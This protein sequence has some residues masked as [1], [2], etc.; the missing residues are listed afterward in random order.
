MQEIIL[1]GVKYTNI[2]NKKS[3]TK[4]AT[5]LTQ[6]NIGLSQSVIDYINS[7]AFYSLINS[8]DIDWNGI[9]LD[10][11]IYINDTSDLINWI[12][13]IE[14]AHKDKE[15]NSEHFSGLGRKT[16]Q[17]KNESNILTQ[18]DFD[19]ENTIYVIS[20]DFDLNNAEITIP[21]GCVLK[22]N[23]GSLNNGTFYGNKCKVIG[24]PKWGNNIIYCDIYDNNGSILYFSKV[25]NK[26]YFGQ[27]TNTDEDVLTN[28]NDIIKDISDTYGEITLVFEKGVTYDFGQAILLRDNMTVEGNGC[29]I[30]FH[31]VKNQNNNWVTMYPYGAFFTNRKLKSTGNTINDFAVDVKYGQKN[32]TIKNI[33]FNFTPQSEEFW[34]FK[35]SERGVIAL[36]GVKNVKIEN[37]KFNG[38]RA[39]YPIWTSNIDGI[40]VHNCE[41]TLDDAS[42][43]S[44]DT[45]GLLWNL[46][47]Y[48]KDVEISHNKAICYNDEV[49]GLSGLEGTLYVHDNDFTCI[50]QISISISEGQSPKIYIENN[51]FSTISPGEELDVPYS[52]SFQNSGVRNIALLS[53]KNNIYNYCYGVVQV[54]YPHNLSFDKIVI[55]G[56]KFN[57]G[58]CG[59]DTMRVIVKDAEFYNNYCAK[60]I[61]FVTSTGGTNNFTRIQNNETGIIEDK[62][63][64]N[65][66][67]L[68][69]QNSISYANG[70]TIVTGNIFYGSINFQSSAY[71]N[72]L[73]FSNNNCTF[74][75][76]NPLSMKRNIITG[77]FF[78]KHYIQLNPEVNTKFS[79]NIVVD[80]YGNLLN[81]G[82][83]TL[84]EINNR[85]KYHSIGEIILVDDKFATITRDGFDYIELEQPSSKLSLKLTYL[86]GLSFNN[87]LGTVN[88]YDGS[89]VALNGPTKVTLTG[90]TFSDND[91]EKD[92]EGFQDPSESLIGGVVGD[93]FTID[94]SNKTSVRQLI[95]NNAHFV[96][97]F[98]LSNLK[99][100]S[101]EKL[102]I[103]DWGGKVIGDI[104]N[105][106]SIL[107]SLTTL[108]LIGTNITGDVSILSNCTNLG[109]DWS[110]VMNQSALHGDISSIPGNVV[111][112]NLPSWG[113]DSSLASA[114][115]EGLTWTP[116]VRTG[117][118]KSILCLNSVNSD[119]RFASSEDID[120]YFIDNAT[121][122][123][124]GGE[125]NSISLF[126]LGN[127]TPSNEAREAITMLKTKGIESIKINLIGL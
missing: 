112:L 118:D 80:S 83:Y 58:V 24:I 77:N 109:N 69:I 44:L 39:T 1:K 35:N 89:V 28:F 66:N 82:S 97:S 124:N 84:S 48:I 3:G 96:E 60:G 99:G 25:T 85:R 119:Q 29:I 20:N 15:Y 103:V 42:Q 46:H 63:A 71:T 64:V 34:F 117:T 125:Y 108:W 12:K 75:Y 38:V 113:K 91:T 13:S 6:S 79:D 33:N 8:I 70:T 17:L 21:E 62:D 73:I 49:I 23:G 122:T 121:C 61:R 88:S 126:V 56:N 36:N 87:N 94:I 120:N 116:G 102:C 105:I 31:T 37:C 65:L 40:I 127:Y 26:T 50:E 72:T 76:F 98:K 43:S 7:N 4:V 51:T 18:E 32:I 78:R 115:Y 19:Q 55:E 107:P 30:Q 41:L 95:I 68:P 92:F 27:P 110:Q 22:F 67:N 111:V 54:H 101:L 123:F 10:E 5:M 114:G 53:V 93:P 106:S 104:S 90:A 2:P 45:C 11:G 47:G 74:G 57:D 9:Q 100:T 14:K 81:H 52:L 16:L 86:D 59:I